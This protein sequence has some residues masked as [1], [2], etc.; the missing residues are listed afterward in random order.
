MSFGE[1]LTCEL[2]QAI[3]DKELL[4]QLELERMWRVL[5]KEPLGSYFASED[6]VD[7]G[8]EGASFNRRTLRQE[9]G[10]RVEAFQSLLAAILDRL[11][12]E[13]GGSDPLLA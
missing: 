1:F 12:S 3:L 4:S 8:D 7:I 11:L 9:D 13:S 2:V 6:R 5:P 10:I